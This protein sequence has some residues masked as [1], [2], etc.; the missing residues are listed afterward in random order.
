MRL[1][2]TLLLVSAIFGLY[3]SSYAQEGCPEGAFTLSPLTLQ[4]EAQLQ[5]LPELKMPPG[6]GSRDL[7]YM[8]DN[9]TQIY[10]RPAFQQDGLC[11]GQASAIGYN[12]TYEM[13]RERD[14]NANLPQ[15][16]YVTHFAWNFMNG[17]EG[18]YGVSYLHSIQI[19]KEFGM[20][21]VV[22][23]GGALGFGGPKRWMSG[24]TLYYNSMHNR[25]T[26]A[27]QIPV[28]TPEGLLVL[29]HWL[30]SH[31]ED[32]PI[33]GIA[34]FYAQYMSA[35]DV[36]PAGTPEAGKYVLTNF[37]GSPNHAMTIVGYN[38]SIRWDYNNDGQY[39][40]D[41]DINGDNVVDMK[42]WETGGFKMVQSYGGGPNWGNGGY[43][44]MM[45][46]TVADVLGN[47]GIWNHCVHVLD[48]K[49]TYDPK[50]TAKIIIKHSLRKM[51][52][53]NVGISNNVTLAKPQITLGFPIYDYQG[54]DNFMQGGSSEEDKTIE[55]GLD[56][57][58]L[59]SYINL[60]QP[61]KVF[62]QVI[63][64]DPNNTNSGEIICF[65]IFDY[66]SG[67]T[68][69]I[70][71]QANV[72]LVNDDTTTLSVTHAFSF[73]RVA[74]MDES[75]PPA[76]E[77]EYYS[78]Q[79]TA[80]GGTEPY[81]WEFDKTYGESS[82]TASFPQ[83]HASQLTPSNNSNGS[84]LQNLDFAFP[85]FDSAYS[86]IRIYV[87]GYIMFDN[88]LY[89]FPYF[90]DDKGLF[91]ITRNISPFM[92]Q[93]QEI[94]GSQGGGIWYEGDT[95]S[96]TIRWKTSL[97]EDPSAHMN[98]AVRLYPD[99]T[100]KFYYGSMTGCD[101]FLWIAGISDG[102]NFNYQTT[103]ISNK[104][105]ITNNTAT[106]L[107]RYNYP[108]EMQLDKNGLFYGTPSQSYN[109]NQVTFRVT[110]NNFIH[111][112]KTFNFSASGIIVQ[113][114]VVSGGDGIIAFGETAWMNVKILNIRSEAITDATMTI[115]I[116]D[117]Y[118]TLVDS[119]ES[120]GT[121]G[122]GMTKICLNAF[123]FIVADDVP[124]NHLIT[125]QTIID[126]DTNSWECGLFHYAF[127]P[128]VIADQVEVDDENGRLDAGDTT[129]VKI[130]FLNSGGVDVTS[131]YAVLSTD[132][133]YITIND[134]FKNIPLI[135]PGQTV[136]VSF[137][138]TVSTD[139]PPAHSIDFLLDMMGDGNY[140]TSD[141][142]TLVVGLYIENFESGNMDLFKWGNGGTQ[143]WVTDSYSPQEGIYCAR[144]G[145][146]THNEESAMKIDL[147]VLTDGE[148][149]FYEHTSCEDDPA[150]VPDYDY[151]CFKI[152]GVE[153]G[154]WDGA[155]SWTL[156]QFPVTAGFHRFEWAYIKDQ[157]VNFGLDAAWVDYITF[158][159]AI[160]TS[161][162]V[163][164][165]PASFDFYLKPGETET[166]DLILSNN[167]HGELDFT[168]DISSIE[169]SDR[170]NPPAGRNIE[171][172]SLVCNATKFNTGKEYLWNL[173]TYNAGSD[174]EWIKQIYITFP[175]GLDLTTSSDFT[176]GSG[177]SM[178]FEGPL[179]NGVTA[180][181]YGQDS[182]GWGVVHMGE[183]AACDVTIDALES[184][185]T[186]NI[187]LQ[188]E[189]MGEVYGGPPHTV[190][191]S[192]PLRNLGPE[193]A[194]LNI[195]TT[196][197]SLAG[198]ITDSLMVSVNTDGLADGQYYAWIILK[199][200]FNH[201]IIIPV[202]L[203]VD[204][205]LDAPGNVDISRFGILKAS[206]D[207]FRDQTEISIKL[208]EKS[209]L[210]FEISNMQGKL[211]RSFSTYAEAGTEMNI[212]WD[213]NDNNGHHVPAGLYLGR[214]IAG[215]RS[216][217]VKLIHTW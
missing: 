202:S 47:G 106:N 145:V 96:A 102:D 163:T 19:L 142:F 193:I 79:L 208:R 127:A 209:D 168:A 71:P 59:L 45:Y 95:N 169:P 26:N 40:N 133:P 63:E 180:H 123:H 84:V 177:G 158:P 65:S 113:D 21:N 195:D 112:T 161:P 107:L 93:H 78:Y 175:T 171:G 166:G 9:S 83:V 58:K 38:D 188:Y 36:L 140:S 46:K 181:W 66:T 23:Y 1:I 122:S 196:A 204:T 126:S 116:S 205:F 124:D 64:D 11:C 217:F 70:C 150:Q 30:H 174:N 213:G 5:C 89:P 53:V 138:L 62:L 146:I 179:G 56:L 192:I 156:Q 2:P 13:S 136:D 189:V 121:I 119:T 128:V 115:H 201:E 48:V 131:L 60:N 147:E 85:F 14:L 49:E 104:P 212:I 152:D 52:K 97:V 197:G 100:I 80:A 155:T 98:Y 153:M 4:E 135:A 82:Q 68:E 25:I 44:Y 6:Y 32:S 170:E 87:D 149:S 101:E 73:E 75:I 165:S 74:I 31:L 134:V 35:T 81:I 43:A 105:A 3:G 67:G 215:D 109:N 207:P 191:G 211:I 92:N 190:Y 120:L 210:K 162:S 55:F 114:S 216:Y 132:D 99:G 176:G 206:P 125:V 61:V 28:G 117:P 178:F 72:P 111:T 159:S 157:S 186:S 214:M 34:S 184:L 173:R 137:N 164:S 91:N 108:P 69:V 118:I 76:P 20:P 90:Q 148:I 143:D 57:S 130:S 86:S 16:Q 203:T 160:I 172:S 199:D 18:W 33:G 42:D 187:Q 50:L 167:A 39:T 144:S 198:G 94:S 37:G 7:P 22:D 77:G 194:W 183:T 29:K 129:D 103:S 12:F 141:S 151:L 200:N 54:G 154:R 41:I 51:I 24:Y 10:M 8:V 185:Q 182:S 15:N 27:Y 139:C 17:G 110:D 88:Q